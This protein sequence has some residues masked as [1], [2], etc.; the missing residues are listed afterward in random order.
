MAGRVIGVEYLQNFPI[1]L[2]LILAVNMQGWPERLLFSA[3]GAAGTALVIFL[4]EGLKLKKPNTER[5][6]DFVINAASFFVAAVVYLAYFALMRARFAQPLISDIAFGGG[7]GFLIG[8]AQ[9]LFVDERRLSRAALGHAA[10]LALAGA[11]ILGLIGLLAQY[12]TPLP[13]ASVLCLLMTLI[14]VRFDYWLLVI[15]RT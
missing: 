2:S 3:V 10:A 4:T 8:T 14:I 15:G 5:P 1:V 7:L 9:A 6:I 11:S 12:W 13:A